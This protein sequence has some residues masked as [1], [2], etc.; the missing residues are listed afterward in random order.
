VGGWLGCLSCSDRDLELNQ[1]RGCCAAAIFCRFGGR[2]STSGVEAISQPGHG[3]S[4][5][6]LC[7]VMRSPRKAGGPWLRLVVGRGLP[8]CRSLFLSG[9]ALRTS[10]SGGGGAQG[11]DCLGSFS[12]RVLV[13]KRTTFSVI[14]VSPRARLQ[15]LFL[16]PVPAL[17]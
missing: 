4:K 10:A 11:L 9:D 13:V 17:F 15:R 3:S 14:R 7:E 12:S 16:Y 5:P 1:A 8:S 2:F 6:A